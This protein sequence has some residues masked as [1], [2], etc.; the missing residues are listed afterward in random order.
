MG[1]KTYLRR[2]ALEVLL[3]RWLPVIARFTQWFNAVPG[4]KRGTAAAL[5]A[6]AKA[7]EVLGRQDWAAAITT[8]NDWAQ[9]A[10]VPGMDVVGGLMAVVGLLHPYF[11][12][13]ASSTVEAKEAH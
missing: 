10:L 7:L 6:A 4:R 12:G 3:E 8:A 5:L 9:T 2:K 1:L 11:A 13:H